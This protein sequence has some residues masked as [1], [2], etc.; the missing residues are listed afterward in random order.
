MR[1]RWGYK[2]N[3]FGKNK[4]IKLKKKTS[5]VMTA[6]ELKSRMWIVE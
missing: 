1:K 4:K 5:A 3:V 2:P 6:F